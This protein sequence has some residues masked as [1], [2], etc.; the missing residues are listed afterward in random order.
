MFAYYIRLAAL[1]IRRNPV[2]STL[3][4]AAIAVGIGAFMT[5]LTVYHIQS[6]N[7]IWWKNDQLYH[8]QVDTWDPDQP[9]DDSRPEMAPTQL[10]WRDATALQ[11]SDIPTY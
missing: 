1:S 2:L 3:M 11:Q 6:G 8:P 7:P 4:M 5:M 9:Y 10:T